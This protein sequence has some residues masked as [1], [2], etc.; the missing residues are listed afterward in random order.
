MHKYLIDWSWLT[1]YWRGGFCLLEIDIRTKRRE[2]TYQFLTNKGAYN[3]FS[4]ERG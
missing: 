3:S 4:S 1:V 2:Y